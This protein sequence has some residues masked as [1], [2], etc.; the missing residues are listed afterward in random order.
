MAARFSYLFLHSVYGDVIYHV[1][2]EKLHCTFLNG[3]LLKKK[4]NV[5]W[6][7]YEKIFGLYSFCKDLWGLQESPNHTTLMYSL[8]TSFQPGHNQTSCINLRIPKIQFY[9][10]LIL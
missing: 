9:L 2:S 6:Y 10:L 5:S 8:Q 7:S 1:A 4:S 3:L